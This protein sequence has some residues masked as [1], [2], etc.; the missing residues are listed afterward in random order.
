M[1][2][3]IA[4]DVVLAN[5]TLIHAT[6]TSHPEIYWALRG[7]ADS[8]GIVTT[9]YLQTHPAPPSVVRF[10]YVFDG[11]YDSKDEFRE[12]FLHLQDVAQNASVMDNKS[13]Y[14]FYLDSNNTYSFSGIYFGSVD[15]YN[16]ALAPELLRTL[17]PANGT[18]KSVSWYDFLLEVSH[19]ET[20]KTTP[21]EY[22]LHANFFAKSIA[23]PETDPLT[24]T[25][26]DA[27]FDHL[28]T[29]GSIHWFIE[30]YLH[31]GPGSLINTKDTSFAA[32][33]DR[34][35]LWVMQNYGFGDESVDFVNGINQ[36]VYDA[37]PQTKFGA[38]LNYVDPTYDA[39]TA[40]EIYF[41]EEV[42]G[43]LERIKA[44]VDP[45]MVF[46]HP[47]AIGVGA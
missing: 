45:G 26:L 8:F 43:R 39:Q 47:Q 44:E 6:S 30:I 5:G 38:Y 13:S 12:I 33:T 9:F 25:A 19:K 2:Q 42:Y 32:Y 18:V 14:E 41:G 3:I 24:A 15:E 17:P 36:A 35:N 31:G 16:S 29:A 22:D 23:V 10:K 11:V 34:A 4:L 40:H 46:W 7:A 1:D 28:H 37:M 21:G 20:I 27:L